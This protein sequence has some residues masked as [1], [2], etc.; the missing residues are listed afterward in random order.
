MGC[1][2]DDEF[3]GL[4]GAIIVIKVEGYYKY[5]CGCIYK[6]KPVKKGVVW[7]HVATGSKCGH[8]TDKGREEVFCLYPGAFASAS[9]VTKLEADLNVLQRSEI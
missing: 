7:S 9:L 1:S 5:D 4:R 6:V 3:W 8:Y 2:E